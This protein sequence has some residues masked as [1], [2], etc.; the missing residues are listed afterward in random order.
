[1]LLNF[2]KYTHSEQKELTTLTIFSKRG[3][4]GVPVS[5]LKGQGGER[6]E[7]NQGG[8]WHQMSRIVFHAERLCQSWTAQP[9]ASLLSW[10]LK[11]VLYLTKLKN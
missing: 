4:E 6:G 11:D 7:E 9:G 3:G 2:Y 5:V 8:E 1:M 10:D